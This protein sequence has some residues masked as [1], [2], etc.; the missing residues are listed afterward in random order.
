MNTN[1]LFSILKQA[2]YYTKKNLALSLDKEGDD[3]DY[4]IK[5]LLREKILIPLKKG[6]YI[7]SYYKDLASQNPQEYN[8][9]LEYLANIIRLPSYVSLE[10][11]LSKYS[12]IPE[13]AFIMTSVTEKSS[14]RYLSDITLFNYRSIK[15]ELFFGYNLLDF[16][17][18]KVKVASLAK[19]LFD[20]L[21]LKKTTSLKDMESYLFQEARINW[22]VLLKRDKEEFKT[23]IKISSS[24]KMESIVNILEK[25]GIL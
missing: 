10:Y 13:A 14:R 5:K 25:E 11:V 1:T 9:Y 8:S 20:Y 19:A 22:E 6:L 15:K 12:L 21:Y 3:L 16:R 4:W 23:I 18:K 7:S 2:P 24:S 17:D